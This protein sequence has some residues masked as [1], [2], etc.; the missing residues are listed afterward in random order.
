MKKDKYLYFK[1]IRNKWNFNPVERVKKSKKNNY[2]RKKIS[3]V[4]DIQ[5]LEKYFEN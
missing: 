1:K 2:K 3:Q 5:E 4:N